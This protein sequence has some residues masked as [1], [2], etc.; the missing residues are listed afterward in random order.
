MPSPA[1]CWG[2]E[3]TRGGVRGVAG[4]CRCRCGGV[5]FGV[6]LPLGVRARPHCNEVL[7]IRVTRAESVRC[8][9][10]NAP[11]AARLFVF[12]ANVRSVSSLA[13]VNQST[14]HCNPG[15]C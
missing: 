12:I 9:I 1:L 10:A 8:R 5:E 6:K 11:P 14:A 15:S 4:A 3:G 7:P 13:E 2:V